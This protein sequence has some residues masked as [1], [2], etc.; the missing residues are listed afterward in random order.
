MLFQVLTSL[1]TGR[2]GSKN[3]SEAI[4]EFTKARYVRLRF[5][6]IRTLNADLM[7]GRRNIDLSVMRRVR[8][9]GVRLIFRAPPSVERLRRLQLANIYVRNLADKSMMIIFQYF[10]TVKDISIGGQCICYGH[11]AECP[12][13]V[14]TGQFKCKCQH[15]TCGESCNECCPLYNQRPWK[16]GMPKEPNVCQ[17]CQ[18]SEKW[19]MA[20]SYN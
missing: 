13:D 16:P 6:K 17:Q 1:I 5:Q 7:S 4:Q 19:D 10:Y 15:N 14:E 2:P 18:V 20:A 3:R 9:V 8:S 12:N 11:A